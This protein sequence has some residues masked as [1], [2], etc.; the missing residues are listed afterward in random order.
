MDFPPKPI[1]YFD[2]PPN[3]T[4]SKIDGYITAIHNWLKET[5]GIK[6]DNPKLERDLEWWHI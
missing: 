5:H 4:L 2:E 3:V 6:D 1:L